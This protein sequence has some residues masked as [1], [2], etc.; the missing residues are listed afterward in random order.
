MNGIC[1]FQLHS[2][3]TGMSVCNRNRNM[4]SAAFSLYVHPHQISECP[5]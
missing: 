3:E 4:I 5:A 1:R 2:A